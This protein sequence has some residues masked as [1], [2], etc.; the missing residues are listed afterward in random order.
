MNDR[1]KS[2]LT[3]VVTIGALLLG[4]FVTLYTVNVLVVVPS[5]KEFERKC[6]IAN[7]VVWRGGKYQPNRC[8]PKEMIIKIQ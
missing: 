6:K 8:V 4:I 7:G 3:I 2:L 1:I 5:E